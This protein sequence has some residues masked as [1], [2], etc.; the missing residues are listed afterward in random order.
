MTIPEIFHKFYK[1]VTLTLDVVSFYGN[2]F[3]IMSASKPKFMTVDKIPIQ[4]TGKLS[5]GLNKVIKLYGIGGFI[6]GI[7][8]MDMEFDKVA[9][10]L[11]KVEVKIIAAL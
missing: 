6:I 4:T 9:D 11:V 8:I 1:F 2:A 7:I 10:K 3:L 5:I